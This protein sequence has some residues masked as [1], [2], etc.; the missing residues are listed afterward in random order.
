LRACC[1]LFVAVPVAAD[2]RSAT[3]F[4]IVEQARHDVC[5]WQCPHHRGSKSEA[6]RNGS[7]VHS[8][9]SQQ[10]CNNKAGR[11]DGNSTLLDRLLGQ[12]S[13]SWYN[14]NNAGCHSFCL[15]SIECR[16][17]ACSGAAHSESIACAC[18][19]RPVYVRTQS[20]AA[21]VLYKAGTE[22]MCG[23]EWQGGTLSW[24]ALD[25]TSE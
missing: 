8:S 16:G 3:V 7:K 19:C 2:A 21:R 1:T 24:T 25:L 14:C 23:Q 11:L 4:V 15:V 5:R 17:N 20:L 6:S 10:Q 12:G 18:L 13:N 22:F 9:L